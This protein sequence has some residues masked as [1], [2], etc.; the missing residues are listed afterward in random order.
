MLE[1]TVGGTIALAILTKYTLPLWTEAKAYP[2]F[3]S[4]ATVVES[5]V[6]AVAA[7]VGAH[8]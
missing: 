5:F 4:F 6:R 1:K 8:I 3:A 7:S 2:I